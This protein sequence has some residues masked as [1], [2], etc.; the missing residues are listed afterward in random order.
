MGPGTGAA[1]RIEAGNRI[2]KTL[3]LCYF[4]LREPLVQTQ[5]LPYLRELAASGIEVHLLTFE[6]QMRQEWNEQSRA[7]EITRLAGQGVKW[8]ALPYHKR[9]SVPATIFDIVAGAW[10]ALRLVRRNRIDVIHARAHIPLAMIL[11]LRRLTKCFLVFDIRGL[12]AEEYVDAGV[13]TTDSL[14]F[15]AI[16]LLERAGLKQ[17]HQI[18]VLTRAMSDWLVRKGYASS[19]KIEVIPCCVDFARYSDAQCLDKTEG[20]RFEIVYAGSVTGLYL[21][22]EMA[23][24]F[25]ALRVHEPRA[26]FRILTMSPADDVSARLRRFGLEPEQFWVGE[27]SAQEVPRN[28]H[29]ARLGVSFRKPTFSQIAASPTKIPEYLAAGL[30]VVS[31]AGIGDIDSLLESERV[32]VVI[33]DFSPAEFARA[34]K[35]AY[36]LAQEV[37]VR[38]RCVDIARRH[39]DLK[40]VGGKGYLNVYRRIG[41]ALNAA[42]RMRQAAS[43]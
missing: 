34:A 25:S 11:I 29:R 23:A 36:A 32:G 40:A 19:D 6:R 9:P 14:K 28:L 12:M 5:V 16:K 31:N 17:A 13:W 10:T 20:S 27:V 42:H 21:L 18:V 4:G 37:G 38:Q 24:F 22:E 1:A 39:F 30:P 7:E 33:Q 15:K 2:V 3:Y 35:V 41:E 43:D 26:F 8:S